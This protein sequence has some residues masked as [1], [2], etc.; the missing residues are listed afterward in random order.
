MAIKAITVDFYGTLVRNNDAI[1]RD[2]CRRIS[3]SARKMMVSPI[4]VGTA[5]W[6]IVEGMFLEEF[7]DSKTIEENAI[8]KLIE[9]F[10]SSENPKHIYSEIISS[11]R[12]PIEYSDTHMFIDNLPLPMLIVANGDSDI[13]EDALYNLKIDT[14]N[15]IC[16]SDV[17]AYKPSEKIF[18]AAIKKTGCLANEILHVASS[19]KYDI[20]PAKKAGMNTC[21]VNRL[22]KKK[23]INISAD[24]ECRSL[25]DLKMIIK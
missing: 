22:N 14:D 15:L 17:K 19:L 18:V 11:L 25:L 7:I 4:D 9:L 12:R 21:Y 23:D 1:V 13:V 24:V 16:S 10:N 6:R 3:Q 20:A 2:I 5:W 8:I